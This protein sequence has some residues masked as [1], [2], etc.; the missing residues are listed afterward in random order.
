MLREARVFCSSSPRHLG[1]WQGEDAEEA[2]ISAPSSVIHHRQP[3][4]LPF[5]SSSDLQSPLPTSCVCFSLEFFWIENW[6]SFFPGHEA[7]KSWQLPSTPTTHKERKMNLKPLSSALYSSTP[8]SSDPLLE[9]C[10]IKKYLYSK[11]THWTGHSL[12]HTVLGDCNYAFTLYPKI[13]CLPIQIQEWPSKP[14]LCLIHY[15]SF[16]LSYVHR[17]VTN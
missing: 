5:P 6:N 11:T 10:D 9:L 12:L 17:L 8:L 7:R 15:H 13:L 3:P 1:S 16:R 14:A 4:L 2:D